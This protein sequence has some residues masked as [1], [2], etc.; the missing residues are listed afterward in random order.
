M[1][2]PTTTRRALAPG[3]IGWGLGGGWHRGYDRVMA[4][5]AG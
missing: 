3:E 2:L 5:G 4:W 1:G